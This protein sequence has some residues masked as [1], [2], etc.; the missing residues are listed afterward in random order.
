MLSKEE[1]KKYIEELK[2][3]NIKFYSSDRG[4]G[5]LKDFQYTFKESYISIP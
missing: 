3:E 5:A 2:I 1:C 4:Q